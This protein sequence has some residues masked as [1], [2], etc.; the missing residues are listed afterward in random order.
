[1]RAGVAA[2]GRRDGRSRLLAARERVLHLLRSYPR[3]SGPR[4]PAGESRQRLRPPLGRCNGVQGRAVRHHGDDRARDV[5]LRIDGALFRVAETAALRRAA[6]EMLA[7]AVEAVDSYAA[8][9][10]A[11]ARKD[12]TVRVGG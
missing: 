2:R 7:R 1:M 3:E 4:D 11:M 5:T 8:T 9:A 12:D 10:R 6:G